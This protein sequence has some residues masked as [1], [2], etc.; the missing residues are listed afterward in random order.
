[1]ALELNSKKF[2][3][4]NFDNSSLKKDLNLFKHETALYS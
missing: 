4:D 1:M 2:F 3:D